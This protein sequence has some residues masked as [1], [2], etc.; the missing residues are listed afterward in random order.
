MA[1]YVDVNE[2]AFNGGDT[3]PGTR[4]QIAERNKATQEVV[5]KQIETAKQLQ[6][7]RQSHLNEVA[8]IEDEFLAGKTQYSGD[9]VQP[10]YEP[11]GLSGGK[12]SG[13]Y[14]RKEMAAARESQ[15]ESGSQKQEKPALTA[16]PDEKK[17][18][19]DK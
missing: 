19:K 4:E 12:D 1:E 17:A 15:G 10:A 5:D 14:T 3:A 9:P 13:R 16:A 7:A 2:Y 8:D 11:V 6:E 18:S